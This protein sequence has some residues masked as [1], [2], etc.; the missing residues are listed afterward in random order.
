MN[1]VKSEDIKLYPCSNR[2]GE[3]NPEARLGTEFNITKMNSAIASRKSFVIEY[4]DN[5]IEFSI[6][7]YYFRIDNISNYLPNTDDLY[8]NIKIGDKGDDSYH[9]PNLQPLIE[10]TTYELDYTDET[11]VGLSLTSEPSSGCESLLLLKKDSEDNWTVPLTSKLYKSGEDILPD[12]TANQNIG[13]KSLAFNEIYAKTINA[14]SLHG[15]AD[16]AKEFNEE[17]SI[18]LSGHITGTISSTGKDGW[19]IGTTISNNAVKTAM[20]SDSQVTTAKINN[21]AVTTAKLANNSVTEDKIA[22]GTITDDSISNSA[23]IDGNKVKDASIDGNK[24]MPNTIGPEHLG[25]IITTSSSESN[26]ISVS[27][28]QGTGN[29]GGLNITLSCNKVDSAGA[30]D[31]LSNPKN[32]SITGDV[33]SQP[34]PFDGIS[35]VGLSTAII[36]INGQ[37][38]LGTTQPTENGYID[39]GI[40]VSASGNQV[41]KAKFADVA[42]EVTTIKEKQIENKHLNGAIITTNNIEDYAITFNKIADNAII[43]SKYKDNSITG[44]KL[45]ADISISTTG[46]IT[47]TSFYATSDE[48]LKEN[49]IDYKYH[50]SILDL[51][52]KQFN[53]KSDP[54]K[55][56]I[57]CIA[58]ELQTIYPE[59]VE[60]D[61][62][63]YLKIA[64]NKLVYLLLEEVKL[65]KEE[66]KQLKEGN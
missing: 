16:K 22:F 65:L 2:G 17:K 7:G 51:P 59:L 43:T 37:S 25:D 48:R 26:G 21:S 18:T 44:A 64:E 20:I 6:N 55:T 4:K 32:F 53:Y 12:I 49:I 38:I 14:D 42:G 13:S 50:N 40:F 61:K 62:D 31:R 57:G 36:K 63:G 47:A 24:L 33:S 35:D 3:H 10:E 52:V 28:T 30:A 11:F 23:N 46:T 29:V 1:Y 66:I 9:L 41:K 39:D 15:T 45:A 5:Y 8:A 58:Q 27:L 34:M 56:T 54:T 19:N 60:T